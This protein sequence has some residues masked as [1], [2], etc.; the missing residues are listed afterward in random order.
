MRDRNPAGWEVLP[1]ALAIASQT[2]DA[3]AKEI[4]WELRESTAP[5]IRFQAHTDG[6]R[7]K[8][9]NTTLPQHEVT[10]LIH[11]TMQDTARRIIDAPPVADPRVFSNI[12][13]GARF[14]PWALWPAIDPETQPINT[15]VTRVNAL[16]QHFAQTHDGAIPHVCLHRH[17][18][19][20]PWSTPNRSQVVNCGAPRLSRDA[21]KALKRILRTLMAHPRL[22]LPDAL[23]LGDDG[24]PIL[25][26]DD[27][28][29]P[30]SAHARLNAYQIV[31]EISDH[32]SIDHPA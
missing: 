18:P 21:E 29:T 12:P 24:A 6:L 23:R 11:Q 4:P 14:A 26:L 7:W 3:F 28:G 5:Y 27:C 15:L 31:R 2:Y 25:I 20:E 19:D 8:A 1:A 13:E 16:V 30:D 22:G 9:F 10:A 32:I 17:R